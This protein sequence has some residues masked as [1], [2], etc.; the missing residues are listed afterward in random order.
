MR[1]L[2]ALMRQH[3]PP[4][5]TC[6]YS[7]NNRIL[8]ANFRVDLLGGTVCRSRKDPGMSGKR[9]WNSSHDIHPQAAGNGYRHHLGNLNRA[10]GHDVA[11][12]DFASRTVKDQCYTCLK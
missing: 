12:Q 11:T 3:P 7:S 9:E 6:G 8:P 1:P 4:S 5:A 10:L 2:E